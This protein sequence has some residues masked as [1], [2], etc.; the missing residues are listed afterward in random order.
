MSLQHYFYVLKLSRPNSVLLKMAFSPSQ[1]KEFHLPTPEV[2]L[3]CY[4]TQGVPLIPGYLSVITFPKVSDLSPSKQ[5]L[6]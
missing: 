6:E 2:D 5:G 4:V 1:L 3:N